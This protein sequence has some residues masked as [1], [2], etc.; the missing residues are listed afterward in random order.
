M[1]FSLQKNVL[2]LNMGTWEM[3][4]G[5][6]NIWKLDKLKNGN[7]ETM[8]N[9]KMEKMENHKVPYVT[10]WYRMVPYGTIRD[11]MVTYGTLWYHMVP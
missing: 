11:H 3:E 4:N 5:E 10:I 7:V 9:Q 1:V 8:G 6:K 2:F